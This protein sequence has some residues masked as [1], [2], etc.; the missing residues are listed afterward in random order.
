MKNKVPIETFIKPYVSAVIVCGGNSTRMGN[1][2][3]KLMLN[4]LGIPV[5]ARTLMKFEDSQSINEIIIVCKETDILNFWDV[6]KAFDIHKV[7]SIIKGGLT[8]QQSVF[9]GINECSS[10]SE[11]FA[12]HDGARP[13]VEVSDIDSTINLAFKSNAAALG[14]KFKDTVK[15]TGSNNKIIETLNRDKLWSIQ[16]PQVFEKNIYLKAMSIAKENNQDFTDDCALLENV[17]QDV[18]I[19]EGKYS[20]I[21]ITTNDDIAIAEGILLQSNNE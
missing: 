10:Q 18:Y 4:L 17:L 19:Y 12:I 8:R 15:L 13:L 20:N 21:K 5:L 9:C 11:Y 3:N 2:I 14:V 16:T 1:N 6:V 7:K